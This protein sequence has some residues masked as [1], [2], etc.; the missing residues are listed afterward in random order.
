MD[1]PDLT[2]GNPNEIWGAFFQK[3]RPAPRLV[4][5]WV[6]ALHEQK[7]YPQVIACLQNAILHGQ[8]QPW[9]YEV[10]ALNMEIQNYPKEAIER[11]VLSLSD[12][13]DAN[14]ESMMYSG[15]YLTRFGRKPAALTMYRQASRLLPERAEPYAL[16]LKLAKET[17]SPEFV[18]WAAC[19]LLRN[20]WKPDFPQI[21]KDAETALKDQI[22]KAR[23]NNQPDIADSLQAAFLEARSRDLSIR[24]TWNGNADLDM[25][26]EE[27]SGTVCSV[28]SRETQGGGLFLH[29]GVGPDAANA[30]ELY[31]CPV[32][33]AGPYRVRVSNKDGSLVGNRATLTVTIREGFP[34]QV[35]FTRTLVI[36]GEE[37]SLTIDLPKGRR[38]QPRIVTWNPPE[39][40]VAEPAGKKFVLPVSYTTLSAKQEADARRAAVL[41]DFEE[42]RRQPPRAGAFGYAPQV[43]VIQEG[44][45]TS[46]RA[47]VSPD[48]RYVRI[49]IQPVFNDVVD[50]FT[51]S[52]VNGGNASR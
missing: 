51:F 15:A 16:G 3:H 13:G 45:A 17:D 18:A 36:E 4:S 50:V 5:E 21:H 29:D 47:I 31:L 1:Q 38:T 49:G 24:L 7:N 9:M 11:V 26:V 12:F 39:F 40:D 20:Y 46:A 27:P 22:Q 48:R 41:R 25:Q 14:F 30:Y 8:A 32:G 42:S 34:D 35:R 6:M 44:T 52:F 37:A 19:G 28:E 10:L 33:V 23:R 2:K 43:T